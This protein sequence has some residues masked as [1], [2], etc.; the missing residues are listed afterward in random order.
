MLNICYLWGMS[1]LLIMLG[2]VALLSVHGGATKD[3]LAVETVRAIDGPHGKLAVR[4]ATPPGFDPARKQY[5][6]ILIMHGVMATK[7]TPPLPYLARQLA[8]EGY[9]C[10]RFDFNAQGGSEGDLLKNTVPSEIDDAEAVY[11]YACSLPFTRHVSLLGHSQGGVVSAMLAGRLQEQGCPPRSVA[12]LAPGVTLRKYA[13]EGR[14]AGVRCDPVHP[15]ESVRVWWYRFGRD[16]I[17]SA[18]TLPIEEEASRYQGPVC[19]IQGGKDQVIPPED[20]EAFIQVLPSTRYTRIE[21]AGHLFWLYQPRLAS[22]L[23]AFFAQHQ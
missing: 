11:R 19:I 6:V 14:L 5:P 8:R 7:D 21:G 20:V 3:S 16:Y 15:P 10:I 12:L 17:L 23:K 4:M 18:Q 9:V 13:R 2:L 1:H 22:L